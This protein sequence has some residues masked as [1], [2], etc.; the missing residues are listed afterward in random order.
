M[1]QREKRIGYREE[2]EVDLF[3]EGEGRIDAIESIEAIEAIE[4][5]E[6]ID[7]IEA[8]ETIEGI[9]IIGDKGTL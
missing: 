8:I 7:A 1:R 5:I 2:M 3:I 6:A 9:E 4:S